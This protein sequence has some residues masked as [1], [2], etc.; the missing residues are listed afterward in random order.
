MVVTHIRIHMLD[1]M[2]HH[3]GNETSMR[4]ELHYDYAKDGKTVV[5]T[6]IVH[7]ERADWNK[8]TDPEDPK[9]MID[10]VDALKKYHKDPKLAEKAGWN[11]PSNHPG[12]TNMTKLQVLRASLRDNDDTDARKVLG[13]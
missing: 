3:S 10:V 12:Y 6:H 4:H 13:I 8:V 2:L 9:K 1:G 5:A 7:T 11:E